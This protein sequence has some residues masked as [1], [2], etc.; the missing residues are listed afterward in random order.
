[1]S[2][3]YSSVGHVCTTLAFIPIV[4]GTIV[5]GTIVIGTIVIGTIVIGT[6]VIGTNKQKTN[7]KILSKNKEKIN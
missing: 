2:I 5:I 7:D 4:I 6:I 3:P 1:M